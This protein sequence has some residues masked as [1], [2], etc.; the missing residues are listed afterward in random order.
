MPPSDSRLTPPGPISGPRCS[1]TRRGLE[2]KV[3]EVRDSSRPLPHL[4]FAIADVFPI[5]D[6]GH[7]LGTASIS[8]ATVSGES[9]TINGWRVIEHEA[10]PRHVSPPVE[11]IPVQGP[12]GVVDR[13]YYPVVTYPKNWNR[14]LQAAILEAFDLRSGGSR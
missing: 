3:L 8:I 4:P 12:D 13:R 5:S 10:G 6:G 1:S 11:R 14:A 2:W 9:V 7:L